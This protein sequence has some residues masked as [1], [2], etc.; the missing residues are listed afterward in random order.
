MLYIFFQLFF[1]HSH[2]LIVFKTLSKTLFIFKRYLDS[3]SGVFI[4]KYNPGFIFKTI[5]FIKRENCTNRS[6]LKR[7]RSRI[8]F[9]V[10]V[11]YIHLFA[12]VFSSV[13]VP[14]LPFNQI[15]SRQF[16]NLYIIIEIEQILFILYS[17][18]N[19]WV[20]S[21]KDDPLDSTSHVIHTWLTANY[22]HNAQVTLHKIYIIRN[23]KLNYTS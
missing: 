20:Y 16:T 3:N 19:W 9:R 14:F 13:F 11:I 18:Y 15:C 7:F 17:R 8:L 22:L 4:H 5:F 23:T 21:L 12:F 2:L 10:C 6:Y 1:V